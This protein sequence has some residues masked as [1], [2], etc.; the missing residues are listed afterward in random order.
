M[1][2][3]HPSDAR[4]DTGSTLW[5]TVL[6]H[7][8]LC[9]A[10]FMLGRDAAQASPGIGHDEPTIGQDGTTKPVPSETG[11]C[12]FSRAIEAQLLGELEIAS[13]KD[14]GSRCETCSVVWVGR[15]PR[16]ARTASS[17]SPA[18]DGWSS[19]ISGRTDPAGS[20]TNG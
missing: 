13:R 10:L 19:G 2:R 3:F 15:N 20:A 4:R 11:R 7:A 1:M 5:R 8:G 12:L 9:L 6:A 14:E 16:R 17:R 18:A